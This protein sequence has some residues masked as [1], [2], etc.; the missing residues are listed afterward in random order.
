[1]KSARLPLAA[2]SLALAACAT[3]DT[4]RHD[5]RPSKFETDAAYVAAVESAARKAGVR[6]SWVN[7]PQVRVDAG[8]DG[9]GDE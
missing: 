6:V 8:A 2:A 5:V 3:T 9:D 7:P 4:V 1:M